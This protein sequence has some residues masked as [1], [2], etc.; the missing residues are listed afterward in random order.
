M[1]R[2][3]G[4][5][6]AM[7][8]DEALALGPP[9]DGELATL[10]FEH[11]SLEVEFYAPPGRDEQTPHSRDEIYVGARGTAT[12]FD[13]VDRRPFSA[14]TVAFVAAGETHR[15]EDLSD[16]FA[17]WVMFYGPEGGEPA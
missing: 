6:F 12:F 11:G 8:L 10:V 15:F 5:R 1:S 9:P 4:R 16:D 13:G 7:R 2:G 3:D 17:V 14:G